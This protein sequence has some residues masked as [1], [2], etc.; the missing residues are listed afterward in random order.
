[1]KY[2][3]IKLVKRP[4]LS[5][6]PDLFETVTLETPSLKDGQVLLK[7]THMSLDPA[8][9]GWMS[10]DKNSYIPRVE[11]GD[12]MRSSGVAVVIESRL[13]HFS[14]GNLVTGM[15]GW[16]EYAVST[17][18]GLR[19]IP[20]GI[21]AEAV[22]SVMAL[23]GFTAYQGLMEIGKPKAGETL[24]VSG[25]AG[26]VG[27]IVG[28]IGKAEGLRVVGTAGSDEKCKWL[29]TELGF[30][31]AINYKSD[32][33][34]KQV[35]AA[36]PDGVDLYFENTGGPVQH[37]IFSRMNAHGRIIVCGMIADYN[38]D[39]PSPGPNWMNIVRRRLT[40]Q[41]FT[42]PDHWDKVP[43]ITEKLMA[44]YMAG[45]LK[46]RAHKLQGLES[47]IEG[48]NLL[49]TGGNTGKLMVEL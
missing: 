30:D 40:I 49:F 36:T 9:R 37:I 15:I 11:L 10:E 38:T 42:M 4:T 21:P 29:E 48:I 22:L 34:A 8:M 33:L 31:K 26:S 41:G 18:Q 7:Q 5:I 20:P 16:R 14:V 23:P 47:A 45:N 35:A 46:Y 28:Q 12:I 1:M 3:A 27:S 44:Y 25:A 13:A 2:Q 24:V 43:K 32:T 39:I 6:T 17:G 19:K